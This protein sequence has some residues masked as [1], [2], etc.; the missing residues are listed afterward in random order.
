M[1]KHVINEVNNFISG[2]Y[3]DTTICDKLI[4]YHKNSSEKSDGIT[5]AGRV[6]KSF[7][8][9]T[10][11]VLEDDSLRTQYFN[12]LSLCIEEYV[13]QYKFCNYYSPW[14]IIEYVNIQHYSPKQAYHGWHTERVGNQSY[15]SARH[16]VFMTYL[17]DI[18]DGG[19]TEWFYQ[20]V[21]IKPEKGLT[22][23]WPTDWTFTHRGIASNSQDKYITTGWFSYN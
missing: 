23:I 7:K 3:I 20:N 14:S 22:V 2:W 18:D 4:D 6:D 1:K 8:E 19:E 11:C 12:E 13:K 15:V 21:K 5:N 16:L 9:S 17:N 10:D